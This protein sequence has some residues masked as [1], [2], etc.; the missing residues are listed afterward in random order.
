MARAVQ[1]AAGCDAQ[2]IKDLKVADIH[3]TPA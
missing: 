1:R 2:L 3:R